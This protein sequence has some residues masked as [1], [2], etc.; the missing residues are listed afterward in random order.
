MSMTEISFDQNKKKRLF[1]PDGNTIIQK[2]SKNNS[3][4]NN[5]LKD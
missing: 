5:L 4:S 1:F 3:V 2:S